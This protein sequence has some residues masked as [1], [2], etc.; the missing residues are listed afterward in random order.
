MKLECYQVDA[1]ADQ[2]FEGNPA[3]VCPLS[4]WIDD[5]LMQK[6]AM[7]NNL[8][9]TAFFVCE[10]EGFGLRWFTPAVEVDLCGHATLA[11][12][13]VLFNHL[14]YKREQILFHT[15]SGKLTVSKQS[16]GLVMDFP[17]NPAEETKV[18]DGMGDALGA[19]PTT[20]YKADD[21]LFVL[22][23]EKEVAGL[24]P[25]FLKLNSYDTRGI[26][27][28]AESERAEIDFVSR[29]FAPAVGINED[30]VTGSAHTTLAPYWSARLGKKVLKARQISK[31]GGT[32]NC[33][34]KENRVEI[35]GRAKTYM[36][37]IIVFE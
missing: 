30:P 11:T 2:V 15:N 33:T 19:A 27:V 24:D 10:N 26:I 14:G 13:H 21:Y 35:A 17:S 29:F 28:T 6:I 22:E 31:R 25:D 36:N 12:A 37:G 18:P 9:E 34:M 20:A 1:F 32:V 7:E 8:S 23:S 16:D 3:A 5:N 4:R